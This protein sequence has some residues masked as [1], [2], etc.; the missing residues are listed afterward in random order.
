MECS[1]KAFE[2]GLRWCGISDEV[3]LAI[4]DSEMMAL[5]RQY[6]LEFLSGEDVK[7][8]FSLDGDDPILLCYTNPRIQGIGVTHNKRVCHAVFLPDPSVLH[9][10]NYERISCVVRGWYSLK[11]KHQKRH[12]VIDKIIRILRII[13]E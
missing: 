8:P 3:S 1:K 5:T 11:R 10:M 6:E 13:K 9:D 12:F 7:L 2:D 4:Y